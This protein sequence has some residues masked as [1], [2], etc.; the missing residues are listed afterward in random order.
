MPVVARATFACSESRFTRRPHTLARRLS[1]VSVSTPNPS[2]PRMIK[3]EIG[4][5]TAGLARSPTRLS[6]RRENPALQKALTA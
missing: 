5:I 1:P 3:P 4:R 6:D 2:P